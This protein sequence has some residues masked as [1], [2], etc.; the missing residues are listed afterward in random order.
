MTGKN[1]CWI[2]AKKFPTR[3]GSTFG[4][5]PERGRSPPDEADGSAPGAARQ[6]LFPD[7]RHVSRSLHTHSASKRA[8]IGKRAATGARRSLDSRAPD[9]RRFAGRG[10]CQRPQGPFDLC[11]E[12]LEIERPGTRPSAED[13]ITEGRPI[14]AVSIENRL[15]PTPQPIADDGATNFRTNAHADSGRNRARDDQAREKFA[16]L[17]APTPMYAG[18][19][20]APPEARIRPHARPRP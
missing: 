15:E 16:R 3:G 19:F 20:A 12:I 4:G 7:R 14:Q 6:V 18:E 5:G 10:S 13:D 9:I 1:R 8:G 2:G 11:P 17:A